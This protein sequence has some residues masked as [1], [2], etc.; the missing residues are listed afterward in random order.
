MDAV[1]EEVKSLYSQ[2]PF[3]NSEY[4]L[5]Y[6]LKIL[7]Y[8][9]RLPVPA[10]KKSYFEG[11]QVLDAGCG[12][13]TTVTLLAR[14][15]PKAEVLGVD[16]SL[17]S[18]AIAEENRAKLGLANLH[19]HEGNILEME[20]GR[21]FDVVLSLGVLHHLA[22]MAAGLGN[23]A[24]HLKDDGVVLLWLYGKYGRQR[25]NLN[26]R[27]FRILLQNEPD[28]AEKVRLAKAALG[29]LPQEL[30]ECRFNLPDSAA[31]D[32]FKAA[33]AYVFRNE[34]WL[35]DQFL[36]VNEQTLALDDI[37]AL[38]EGAG[39]IL[40]EWIGVKSDLAAY[41]DNAELVARF[42]RLAAR[43]RLIAIDLLL[44]PSHYVIAARK[45]G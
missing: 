3:P 45:R 17:A 10:G 4:Q 19:F 24:W 29:S 42:E 34:A 36:H 43:D 16:L 38:L 30:I 44:K 27:F 6:V 5:N 26:Q 33:L 1:T 40:D 9:A 39:L 21:K 23:L 41:T 14:M 15:Q 2:Y 18:L 28:M 11:A 20:L 12:T 37:F 8:F 13:G 7:H 31:E 25:L 32:D 22:D 35:V